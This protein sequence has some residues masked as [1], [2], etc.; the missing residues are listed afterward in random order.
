MGMNI[1]LDEKALNDRSWSI[2][3]K[4]NF[5]DK[6]DLVSHMEQETNVWN[7]FQKENG[8]E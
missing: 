1:A 6:P 7:L 2:S 4:K 8:H 3:Q 5:G